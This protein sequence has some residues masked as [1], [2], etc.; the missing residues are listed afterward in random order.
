MQF[1]MRVKTWKCSIFKIKIQCFVRKF[2]ECQE[3]AKDSRKMISAAEA[4]A[5]EKRKEIL[6]PKWEKIHKTPG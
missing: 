4:G 5:G 6:L 3:K 2:G 1:A